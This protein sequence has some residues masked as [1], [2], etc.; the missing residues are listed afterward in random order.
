MEWRGGGRVTITP[1]LHHS[2][3]PFLPRVHC[4]R[5]N[6]FRAELINVANR[7]LTL[8]VQQSVFWHAIDRVTMV[9]EV[10]GTFIGPKS[11][12]EQERVHRDHDAVLGTATRCVR[13]GRVIKKC[14]GMIVKVGAARAERLL[15]TLDQPAPG[16]RLEQETDTALEKMA[17]L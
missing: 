17:G 8:V 9:A 1:P 14:D 2:I 16:T 15:V 7:V 5:I 13:I 4:S 11:I 12:I 10:S 3:T 6:K